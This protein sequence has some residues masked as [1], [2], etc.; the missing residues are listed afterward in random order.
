VALLIVPCTVRWLSASKIWATA[1]VAVL[2]AVCALPL[3]PSSL[4]TRL[5]TTGDEITSGTMNER[6][7]IWNAGATV[8]RS[9]P[10]A[11]VGAGSFPKAVEPLIGKAPVESMEEYD[12]TKGTYVA[13]N[14]FLSVLVETGLIGFAIFCTILLLLVRHILEMPPLEKWLWAVTL[15]VW[16]TAVSVS[17]WETRKPTWIVFSLLLAQ[18]SALRQPAAYRVPRAEADFRSRHDVLLS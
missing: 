15:L 11:G 9:H 5:S 10:F 16:V 12:E 6:T 18:A 17:T 2:L 8:F 4:F 14:T 3:L 1:V 7:I 13:H